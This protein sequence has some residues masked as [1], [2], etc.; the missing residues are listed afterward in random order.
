MACLGRVGFGRSLCGV[1]L[2]PTQ[3]Q[4]LITALPGSIP[5]GTVGHRGDSEL[6]KQIDQGL[7]DLYT[8]GTSGGASAG[9]VPLS[10]HGVVKD[11]S[12]DNT[13]AINACIQDS[14]DE[15]GPGVVDD[16]FPNTIGDQIL[17][18]GRCDFFNKRFEGM[19]VVFTQFLCTDLDAGLDWNAY[20]NAV[21]YGGGGARFSVYGGPIGSPGVANRPMTVGLL[22]MANF[23]QF[24]AWNALS[25]ADGVCLLLAATQN[26]KFDTYWGGGGDVALRLDAGTSAC[27]FTK[28]EL[29]VA[30]R[31][32]LECRADLTSPAGQ[33][34]Y[35][36]YNRFMGE[37]I[38]EAP[39]PTTEHMVDVQAGALIAIDGATISVNAPAFG[40]TNPTGM[41]S[42]VVVRAEES[43]QA[44]MILNDVKFNG[45]NVPDIIGVESVVFGTFGA[46]RVNFRGGSMGNLSLGG[47][48]II[49]IET[50]PW[51]F[52]T[53][54][55]KWDTSAITTLIP[56]FEQSARRY[57]LGEV[58]ADVVLV[59]QLDGES[60]IRWYDR[61]DGSRVY[62]DGTAGTDSSFGR[63]GTASVGNITGFLAAFS[64][65]WNGGH[66]KI[67]G[68]HL[69]FDATYGQLKGKS[70]APAS[71]ADGYPLGAYVGNPAWNGTPL[72]WG[73]NYLWLDPTT[74]PPKLRIKAGTAPTSATDGTVVGTQT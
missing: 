65:N 32:M 2:T 40:G 16:V 5:P 52:S 31:C 61:A 46:A 36:V 74:S 23:E 10:R 43:N 15:G 29:S 35:T 38:I 71:D 9:W 24:R 21:L 51:F 64:A 41:E 19:G 45:G 37:G 59:S 50:P 30:A 33:Q 26:S 28:Y 4:T 69:W 72:I 17:I 13:D 12:T 8:S 25:G 39:L 14:L 49:A 54:T 68:N 20:G 34:A 57:F 44:S 70:S 73:A 56:H 1:P 63:N 18:D 58:A 62:G 55:E 3:I 27:E 6:Y 67:G 7:L 22:N 60:N 11:N 47:N 48:G 53:V 42:I 66:L